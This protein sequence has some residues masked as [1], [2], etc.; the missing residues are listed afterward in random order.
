MIVLFGFD[1]DF[2]E[3]EV[4]KLSRFINEDEEY[5]DGHNEVS[6]RKAKINLKKTL[7]DRYTRIYEHAQANKISV[8]LDSSSIE[9]AINDINEENKLNHTN[10]GEINVNNIREAGKNVCKYHPCDYIYSEF[11]AEKAA[12][13]IDIS[14]EY[15][16]DINK[17]R[18]F[19][20]FLSRENYSENIML[21]VLLTHSL[22]HSHQL[23]TYLFKPLYSCYIV[24]WNRNVLVTKAMMI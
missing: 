5:P 23:L 20:D 1:L 13:M 6:I 17:K 10:K 12:R 14:D 7:N 22:T 3:D 19:I 9:T 2:L 24:M 21:K 8:P 4:A 18:V 11:E 15:D 16:K